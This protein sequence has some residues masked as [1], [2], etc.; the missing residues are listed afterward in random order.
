[1]IQEA[2]RNAKSIEA[3]LTEL[4]SLPDI[5]LTP[6]EKEEIARV[7]DNRNCMSLKGGSAEHSGD[8]MPDRWVLNAELEAVAGRWQIDPWHDLS[9]N[10]PPTAQSP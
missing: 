3:K 8:A 2:G 10:M 4:A 7:G 6:E 5:T 9:Y 1:L